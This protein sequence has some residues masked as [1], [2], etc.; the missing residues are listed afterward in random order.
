MATGG[1]MRRLAASGA[2]Y[3]SR[4]TTANTRPFDW[5]RDC[6]GPGC[7]AAAIAAS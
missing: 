7:S 1:D 5:Y 4:V 3:Q 6:D 2:P